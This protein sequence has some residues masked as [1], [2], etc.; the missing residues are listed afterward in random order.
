MSFRE[1]SVQGRSDARSG[2]WWSTVLRSRACD[3]YRIGGVAIDTI[4]LISNRQLNGN[5]RTY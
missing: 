2:H 5:G 3:N 1:A 4:D